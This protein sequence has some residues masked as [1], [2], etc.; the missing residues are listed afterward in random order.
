MVDE[1]SFG[2]YLNILCQT[3]QKKNSILD[4]LLLLDRQQEQVAK[5]D[6]ASV[7][8]FQTILDQKAPLLDELEHL[9]N[10]FELSYSR[11][12]DGFS[13]YKD[14]YQSVIRTMQE[15][16]V[17]ISKK[18][19]EIQRLEIQNRDRIQIKFSD[20]RKKIKDVNVSSKSISNYYKN[21]SNTFNGEAQFMDKKK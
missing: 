2:I 5:L 7:E 20:M 17:A 14:K 6:T 1:K 12:K 8:E 3:L 10:G 13:I 11:V 18:V 16:I 4:Q 21:M 15:H 19:M 9:D